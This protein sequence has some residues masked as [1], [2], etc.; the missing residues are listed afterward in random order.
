VALLIRESADRLEVGSGACVQIGGRYLV[1]TVKHN[2]QD[3]DGKDLNLSDVE[4]RPR[5]K[6][7]E[8]LRVE[9]AGRSPDLDLAWLELDPQ[10]L[11]LPNLHFATASEI[12]LPAGRG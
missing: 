9:R 8:G 2:I 7:G 3:D 6:N 1:A 10:S 12:T 5:G 11:P 4:V